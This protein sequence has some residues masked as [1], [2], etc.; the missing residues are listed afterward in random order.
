MAF[1]KIRGSLRVQLDEFGGRMRGLASCLASRPKIAHRG[2]IGPF[3]RQSA[4]AVRPEE[5]GSLV[6]RVRGFLERGQLHCPDGVQAIQALAAR[7]ER[8]NFLFPD[9]GRR[10]ELSDSV[11]ELAVGASGA[12]GARPVVCRT[13]GV[14]PFARNERRFSLASWLRR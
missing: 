1:N 5:S 4:G 10:V 11:K 8:L 9:V 3:A 6:S 2:S 7:L 14:F 13:S 12:D